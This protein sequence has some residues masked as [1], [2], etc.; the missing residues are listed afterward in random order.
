MLAAEVDNFGPGWLRRQLMGMRRCSKAIRLRPVVSNRFIGWEPAR[1]IIKHICYVKIHFSRCF[2]I[3]HSSRLCESQPLLL[4]N[5]PFRRQIRLVRSQTK[6]RI[7]AK[8]WFDFIDPI[9][10]YLYKWFSI[11]DIIRDDGALGSFIIHRCE[12][13]VLL[14]TRCVPA[15][16][17]DI[18]INSNMQGLYTEWLTKYCSGFWFLDG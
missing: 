15:V 18:Y 7:F 10:L 5:H 6:T 14:L 3:A 11:C 1:D 2:E 16:N 13:S 8:M 4:G 12:G 9:F 17:T